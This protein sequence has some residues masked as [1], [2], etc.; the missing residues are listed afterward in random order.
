MN[1]I[2]H[3]KK[4]QWKAAKSPWEH[5]VEGRPSSNNNQPAGEADACVFPEEKGEGECVRTLISHYQ[6]EYF[7]IAKCW[8]VKSWPGIHCYFFY[9]YLHRLRLTSRGW[10]HVRHPILLRS[11]EPVQEC[12]REHPSRLRSHTCFLRV[13]NPHLRVWIWG[14]WWIPLKDHRSTVSSIP[15]SIKILTG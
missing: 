5:P 11:M 8:K 9:S 10:E 1:H 15:R 13:R 12:Q 3:M 6:R 14:R 7:W 4:L 2:L